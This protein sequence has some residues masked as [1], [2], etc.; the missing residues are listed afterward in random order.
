[1]IKHIAGQAEPPIDQSNSFD[2]M[3]LTG[4]DTEGQ[5]HNRAPLV[6]HLVEF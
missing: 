5:A 6:S 3:C 4:W 2:C 1:M